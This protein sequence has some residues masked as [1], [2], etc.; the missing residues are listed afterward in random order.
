ML[1]Q[2]AGQMLGLPLG[3]SRG[4]YWPLMPLLLLLAGL[5]QGTGLGE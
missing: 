4:Q 2:A 1:G 3:L 5:H